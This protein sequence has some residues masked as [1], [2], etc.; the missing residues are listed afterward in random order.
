[1]HI[2]SPISATDNCHRCVFSNSP[3][4]VCMHVPHLF[5]FLQLG[6]DPAEPLSIPPSSLPSPTFAFSPSLSLTLARRPLL[7]SS[8][9]LV[10]RSHF[11]S[12]DTHSLLSPTITVYYTRVVER[13]IEEFYVT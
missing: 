10:F 2:N 8:P 5:S 4:P 12:V 11:P 9:F 1:M 13:S 3:L 7:L 6:P